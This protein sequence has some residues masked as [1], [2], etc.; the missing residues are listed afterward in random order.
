M[1][2]SS[3]VRRRGD[4][5][6][7]LFSSNAKRLQIRLAPLG[8]GV[9]INADGR[10]MPCY[11]GRCLRFQIASEVFLKLPISGLSSLYGRSK[12]FTQ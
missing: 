7:H 6:L 10:A 3:V 9:D 8:P 2:S 12:M 1:S 4:Q 11:G 5:F